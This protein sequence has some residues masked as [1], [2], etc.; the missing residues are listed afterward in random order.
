MT[1]TGS[2]VYQYEVGLPFGTSPYSI[3]LT[4]NQGIKSGTYKLVFKLC[5]NDQVVDTDE[6]YLI[7]KKPVVS[8]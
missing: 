4:V 8:D 2:T 7:V 5:D 6:A 3:P 1:G